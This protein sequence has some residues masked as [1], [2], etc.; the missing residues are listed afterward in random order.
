MRL[1]LRFVPL[2]YYP[3]GFV[4]KHTIQGLIYYLL[5]NSEYSE[6]HDKPRFKFFTF[7]DLYPAGDF[8]P[9]KEKTLVISSPNP[10][11]IR[12]IEENLREMEY[13]YLSTLPCK[14]ISVRIFKPKPSKIF[15]SGSPLVLLKDKNKGIYFSLRDHGDRKFLL[16]RVKENAVKKYNAYYDDELSLND[17][18]I[19]DRWVL[20]KEVA[21]QMA[22]KGKKFLIIGSVWKR[23]EKMYIPKHLRRFYNFIMECGIGE[24][25]S[26]GFGFLN[27]VGEKHGS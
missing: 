25:N 27:V 22:M 5:Q 17:E 18:E 9:N 14:I 26:L 12:A 3:E 13:I 24:K 19:F 15:R 20:K 16:D 11:F 4:N 23:L 7:S 2:K 10:Y 1:V 8:Y 21:V 6:I